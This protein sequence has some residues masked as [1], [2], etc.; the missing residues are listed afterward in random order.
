[1]IVRYSYYSVTLYRNSKSLQ[2]LD[3]VLKK[4]NIIVPGLE[5]QNTVGFLATEE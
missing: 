1:M 5:G 2:F 3:C 4:Q